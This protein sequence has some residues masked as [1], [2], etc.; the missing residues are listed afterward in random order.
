M[1]AIARELGNPE[2]AFVLPADGED[3]DVRVRFFTPSTEVPSCGH[4]TIAA[5]YVRALEQGLSKGARVLQ[6]IGAG[7]L[8]VEIEE[9]EDGHYL[10]VM[11]Q[12]RPRFGQTLDGE[13]LRELLLALGLRDDELC[14]FPVQ[15]VDTGHPKLIVPLRD[16]GRLDAL[17]PNHDAL[18]RFRDELPYSGV[19]VFAL[20]SPGDTVLARARMFAPEI[21]I[22]EDPVTGNGNGPL[23]AYLVHHGI[24]PHD[25]TRLHFRSRQGEAMGRPGLAHVRVD[26]ER[27]EPVRVRVAGNAVVVFRGE[28]VLTNS[29]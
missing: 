14:E 16:A 13:P 9:D 5:H 8:P 28:L 2:T 25:G 19:F 29:T 4:A 26:I 12:A 23:G 15:I 22:P 6:K 18:K 7:I 24:V 11:T 3:H 27:A 17:T 21:G 20:A 1:Q 10:V